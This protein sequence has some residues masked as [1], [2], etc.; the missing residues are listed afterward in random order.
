MDVRREPSGAGPWEVVAARRWLPHAW[1][2]AL[3]CV[4]L[5]PALGVGY[6]LSHDM[7]WVPR[8]ALRPDFLGV[9]TGLPRAVPSDAVLAILGWVVPQMALQ[10]L[11]LL[12][13]L[14]G[15]GIGAAHLLPRDLWVGRLV[16][17][18][19]YVWNP[20]VAER[21]LLGHWPLLL[22][23]GA[24]PWTMRAARR[25][26]LDGRVPVGLLWLVPVGSLSASA[27]LVTAVAVGAFG[28]GG[29]TRRTELRLVAL[30]AAANAPWLV[31]GLLHAGVAR[32][33]RSGAVLFAPNGAGLLPAPLA[34]LGLGGTWDLEVLLPSRSG[35]GALAALGAFLVLVLAGLRPWLASAGRRDAV[36]FAVCWGTGVLTVLLTWGASGLMGWLVVHVPGAGVLRD[37]ARMVA[38]CAPAVA[39]VCG[40]GAARIARAAPTAAARAALATGLALLPLAF[41]PD[42]AF[43]E[44]GRLSAVAYPAAFG[45]TRAVV[46][47]AHQ[48]DPGRDVLLLPFSAYRAPSWN[49]G[50]KV[51]D[52]MGRYLT[53]DYVANDALAVSGTTVTT[54][55][56]E[57]PLVRAVGSVL[58]TS[59]GATLSRRL[60]ALGVGIVVTERDAGPAPAIVGQRLLANRQVVVTR[61]SGTR[62]RTVPFGWWCA[63]AAAWAV[64]AGPPVMAF[65]HELR[66]TVRRRPRRRSG[67]SSMDTGG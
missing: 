12:G 34:A 64:F 35:W 37:G 47:R 27:G 39:V 32:T 3:A 60:A 40:F 48:E 4:L 23:Y 58:R 17:V 15:G 54:I 41:L 66:R 2:I 16:A 21:L 30:V 13:S 38:L 56:G 19:V 50:R 42:A 67:A 31:S 55:P 28:L 7:V 25:A 11:V 29:R 8:L 46:A 14:V 6:V 33:A 22:A 18:S 9:G 43:G 26:R 20:F 52:P 44:S 65:G 45:Q 10:K 36:G 59:R 1:A 51:L 53:P 61:I 24:L 62:P 5:G 57:D 63:M 49:D